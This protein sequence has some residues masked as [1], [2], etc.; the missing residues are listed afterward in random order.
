MPYKNLVKE[1]KALD[2]DQ[3]VKLILS[4]GKKGLIEECTVS[5]E[6]EGHGV[7]FIAATCWRFS[8]LK[9][10]DMTLGEVVSVLKK[11]TLDKITHKDLYGAY[12]E[13]SVDGG[14]DFEDVEWDEG[15]PDEVKEAADLWDLYSTGNIDCE[16]VFHGLESFEIEL[17][18]LTSF[19]VDS[20]T[21]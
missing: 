14:T 16:C 13:D 15:T 5:T 11:K 10:E 21:T 7:S 3:R 6:Y 20:E 17:E 12:N 9:S 18:D 8:T 4:P 19:V 2:Q 1:L